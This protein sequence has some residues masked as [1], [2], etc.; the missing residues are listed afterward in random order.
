MIE[1][2]DLIIMIGIKDLIIMIEIKYLY[3]TSGTFIY[4]LNWSK[5]V[6]F[7]AENT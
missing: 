5:M 1:I 3:Y 4:V 6:V 2:K 7:I